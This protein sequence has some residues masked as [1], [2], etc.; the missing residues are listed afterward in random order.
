LTDFGFY[1][2]REDDS[3]WV[4]ACLYVFVFKKSSE[5]FIEAL[6]RFVTF[7]AKRPAKP[8]FPGRWL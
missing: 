3:H 5:K 6:S 2:P 1:L 4:T 7:A 8:L